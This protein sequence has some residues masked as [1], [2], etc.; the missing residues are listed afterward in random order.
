MLNQKR[1]SGVRIG[2]RRTIGLAVSLF[3]ALVWTGCGDVFRPV[4]TPI[5]APSGTPQSEHLALVVYEGQ[6]GQLC[7]VNSSGA[8]VPNGACADGSAPLANG[9]CLAPG[10]TS[11]ID[12]SGDTDAADVSVGLLSPVPGVPAFAQQYAAL[13]GTGVFVANNDDDTVSSFAQFTPGATPTIIA[14]AAGAQPLAMVEANSNVYVADYGL[15][16][17]SVI[18]EASNF[19]QQE[20]PLNF[21]PVALAANAT[22]NKVYVVSQAAAGQAG[23]VSVITTTD[24][25]VNPTS[26]ADI[27]VGIDPI[28]VISNS[29][30][31][32]M[33]VLNAGDTPPTVSVIDTFLDAVVGVLPLP[34]GISPDFLHF[35][36]HLLRLYVSDP[37]AGEVTVFDASQTGAAQGALP[38]VELA[39]VPISGGHPGPLGVLPDGSRAYVMDTEAT[40]GCDQ[41]TDSGRGRVYVLDGTSLTEIGCITVP[42][43]PT[44][45]SASGDGS[46]VYIIDTAAGFDNDGNYIVSGGT[47][48]ITTSNNQVDTTISQP[49]PPGEFLI[50]LYVVCE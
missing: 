46:K 37:A 26:G 43:P 35:D 4:A 45:I 2:W 7:N 6:A 17:I 47:T 50:P 16:R 36:D 13:E 11:Q 49:T 9:F 25:A 15:Q 29:A 39:A 20:I 8:C 32:E 27:Q 38:P 40:T 18:N 48:V 44:S 34:S 41:T 19:L 1:F 5:S 42:Y 30:G 10:Y 14:L 21:T 23:A 3:F 33:Y 31:S 28:A 12:V 22:G 24:N